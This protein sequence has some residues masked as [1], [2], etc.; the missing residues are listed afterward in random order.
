MT[1][2]RGLHGRH[3]E[4][5]EDSER[6]LMTGPLGQWNPFCWTGRTRMVTTTV[7]FSFL[8]WCLKWRFLTL[9]LFESVRSAFFLLFR[10]YHSFALFYTFLLFIFC[11]NAAVQSIFQPYIFIR[12]QPPS[13]LR[14]FST[15]YI[16]L[17]PSSLVPFPLFLIILEIVRRDYSFPHLSHIKK[18]LLQKWQISHVR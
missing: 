9:D 2:E 8:F 7:T 12:T 3:F 1:L 5:Q 10:F 6:Q 17:H 18:K 11:P 14:I 16:P 15:N 13:S 4:C